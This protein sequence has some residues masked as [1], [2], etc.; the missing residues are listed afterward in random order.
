MAEIE[1]SRIITK[2]GT[3]IATIPPSADHSNGDWIST[4]IYEG[5]L[6]LDEATGKLYTNLAGVI[7]ELNPTGVNL[8]NQDLTQTDAVR[9]YDIDGNTLIFDNGKLYVNTTG[10][11][12]GLFQMEISGTNG[13]ASFTTG[14]SFAASSSS[15]TGITSFGAVKGI[16]ARSVTGIAVEGI[17]SGS[18][19]SGNFEGTVYVETY[20]L[21]GSVEASAALQVKSTTQG[22][23][24]PSM[25]T[26][27]RTSISSPAEGLIVYDNVLKK[28]FGYDGTSWNAF[29]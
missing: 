20:G 1:Y 14:T 26:T 10:G 7:T 29:Y 3:G 17:A 2:K 16:S 15:G 6:Y 4:D 23:L 28:H 9:E 27:E 24:P 19:V 8:S 18:G 13:I 11:T 22:F 5:E 12:G 25:T 21:G